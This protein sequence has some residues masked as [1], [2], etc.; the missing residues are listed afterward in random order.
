MTRMRRYVAQKDRARTQSP[1]WLPD[2][3]GKRR[4]QS[5]MPE[6]HL[7]SAFSRAPGRAPTFHHQLPSA[8]CAK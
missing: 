5:K 6:V 1:L 4:Q 8:N 7:L 3:C 2:F